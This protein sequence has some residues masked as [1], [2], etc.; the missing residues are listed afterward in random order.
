VRLQ[1]DAGA[2]WPRGEV[3][4]SC[5]EPVTSSVPTLVMSGQIE[6]VTPLVWDEETA[7]HLSASKHIVMPGTGHTAGGTGCG[8]RM[9][10]AFLTNGN[11]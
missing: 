10:R 8:V 6:P 5:Y 11:T 9:I 2:S 4:A 3:P 1:Q 7:K